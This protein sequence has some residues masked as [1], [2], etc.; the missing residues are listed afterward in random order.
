MNDIT[1]TLLTYLIH[2]RIIDEHSAAKI[3]EETQQNNHKVLG[4]ILLE[5]NFFTKEDLLI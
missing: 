4:E 1:T 3:R 2:N 5:N